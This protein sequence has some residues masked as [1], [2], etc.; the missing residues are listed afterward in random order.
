VEVG[1]YISDIEKWAISPHGKCI[2]W[3]NGM[4]GTGKSI[5]FRIVACRLNGLLRVSFFKKGEKD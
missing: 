1:I 2:F 5:I 4:A 3:L